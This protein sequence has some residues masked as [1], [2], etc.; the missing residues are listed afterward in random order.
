MVSGHLDLGAGQVDNPTGR[1]PTP[2][3]ISYGLV[4]HPHEKGERN[5]TRPHSSFRRAYRAGQCP[6]SGQ[7]TGRHT[8]SPGNGCSGREG[9]FDPRPTD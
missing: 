2:I 7:A 6:A 5:E 1:K 8:G 4:A 9:R 3:C